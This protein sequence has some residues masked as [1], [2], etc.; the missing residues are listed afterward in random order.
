MYAESFGRVVSGGDEVDPQLA[1]RLQAR[2][3]RLAREVEVVA[4]VSGADHLAARAA[5]ADRDALDLLG[6][7]SEDERLP[8]DRFADSADELLESDRPGQAAPQTDLAERPLDLHRERLREQRVV[9]DLRMCVEREVVCREVQVR[10]EESLQP[11]ALAPVDPDGLV[12]P[13]HPVVDDHELRACLRCPL[14]ELDRAGD[15]AGDLRHLVGAEHLEAGRPVLR[16]AVDFEQFVCEP[17]DLV[18]AG[19]SRDYR[20]PLRARGVAQPGSALRSGRRG[21]EFESPHPDERG[22]TTWFP[23]IL[24]G[25]ARRDQLKPNSGGTMTTTAA[26]QRAKTGR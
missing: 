13:E 21:P 23:H 15:A 25:R 18:A 5:G 3:F 8:A 14:E 6:T 7:V 24:R 2:L 17:D 11:A 9:A 22:G 19:H 1:G 26:A 10:G 4:L 12:P 20:Y 16:E